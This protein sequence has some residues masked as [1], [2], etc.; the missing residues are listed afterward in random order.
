MWRA[1]SQE[2]MGATPADTRR[3]ERVLTNLS[4]IF[5]ALVGWLSI[6]LPIHVRTVLG[7]SDGL[8]LASWLSLHIGLRAPFAAAVAWLGTRLELIAAFS[9]GCGFLLAAQFPARDAAILWMCLLTSPLC[10]LRSAAN[11][12]MKLAA[13]GSTEALAG[14]S[15]ASNKGR[16]LG[17][18]FRS[19]V[20]GGLCQALGFSAVCLIAG[21]LCATFILVAIRN[22]PLPQAAEDDDTGGRADV[23]GGQGT[24]WRRLPCETPWWVW[25]PVAS[26]AL[27][28]FA[29]NSL[30]VTYTVTAS[31]DVGLSQGLIGA[32]HSAGLLC[33]LAIESLGSRCPAE[34]CLKE[35]LRLLVLRLAYSLALFLMALATRAAW[36]FLFAFLVAAGSESMLQKALMEMAVGAAPAQRVQEVLAVMETV[37]AFCAS[38]GVAVGARASALGGPQALNLLGSFAMAHFALELLCFLA[39]GR[40]IFGPGSSASAWRFGAWLQPLLLFQAH[41]GFLAALPADAAGGCARRNKND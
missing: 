36:C 41:G 38:A 12:R 34:L 21:L 24:S 3:Q 7:D 11:L 19:A 26:F 16:L 37:S 35:P 8:K 9:A 17:R 29:M 30:N 10:T 2:K 1:S 22:P 31:R 5:S 39:V 28:E 25:I 13:R 20:V 6:P 14:L 33:A 4:F 23:D 32:A 18:V 15:T 27:H 40:V